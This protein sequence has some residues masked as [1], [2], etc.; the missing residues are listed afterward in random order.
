M[1][2]DQVFAEKLKKARDF[3]FGD[4]TAKVFDDMLDRSVPQYGELQ[5]MI[6]EIA[7]EFAVD[8]TSVYDLGCS[9]GITM[10]TLDSAISK[11]VTIVGMDYS[12]AML[13]ECQEKLDAAEL[14]HPYH[15]A[16][17]D[18]NDGVP[19]T[20][21]S[22]VVLNLT[23][24]FVR[25]IR[26]DSLIRQINQG[27]RP[28]GC[29]ILVEKVLGNDSLSNRLFIQF[30]YDMKKRKGYSELEIAQKREALENVLIPYRID[31]NID[32]LRRNGFTAVDV[33]WKWYNFCGILAVK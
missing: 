19:V 31:E 23:L 29:L 4:G 32:L 10:R 11:D 9:T 18:L 30:Y 20:N 2:R 22:V 17:Q 8:G 7:G 1:D 13:N 25:P 15:L 27:I 26:R 3:D 14:A 5:R 21:A 33:Y 28:G 6:G 12:Q 16:L 24:Q